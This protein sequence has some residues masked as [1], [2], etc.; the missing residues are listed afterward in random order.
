MAVVILVMTYA[1]GN[2]GTQVLSIAGISAVGLTATTTS[3]QARYWRR[4]RFWR[5]RRY[6][7][8]WWW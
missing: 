2:V 8:R 5:G 6:R 3:A 7:R 1:L 4:R